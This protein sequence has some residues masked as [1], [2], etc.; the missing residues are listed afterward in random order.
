[1][2]QKRDR[3]H[4]CFSSRSGKPNEVLR[5][6]RLRCFVP[7][8][9][10]GRTIDG[11]VRVRSVGTVRHVTSQVLEAQ[12]TKTY[13]LADGALALRGAAARVNLGGGGRLFPERT[14]IRQTGI[15]CPRRSHEAQ[16]QLPTMRCATCS[17][18]ASE[19]PRQRVYWRARSTCRCSRRAVMLPATLIAHMAN[20]ICVA[21][22]V[23]L[24]SIPSDGSLSF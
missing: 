23:S 21:P 1:M 10:F 8:P 6:R 9:R 5:G 15:L 19:V 24:H 3:T 17:C 18:G 20:D 11:R 7:I 13:D 22:G 14:M 12:L 2:E 16:S 4:G